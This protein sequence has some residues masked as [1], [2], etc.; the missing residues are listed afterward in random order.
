MRWKVHE[1]NA[2]QISGWSL[3]VIEIKIRWGRSLLVWACSC[4]GCVILGCMVW[5]GMWFSVWGEHGYFSS[6]TCQSVCVL[7]LWCE[8]SRD[9]G[10]TPGES[11]EGSVSLGNGE[12]QLHGL[13]QVQGLLQ[14]QAMVVCRN[15]ELCSW[16]DALVGC[17]CDLLS[18][19]TLWA[20]LC[21]KQHGNNL[22]STKREG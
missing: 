6:Q 21:S 13:Y 1:P 18:Y 16:A 12:V 10:N 5:L 11:C 2:E 8:G 7:E 9:K 20:R 14:K 22:C 4:S 15:P 3:P 19:T 17:G